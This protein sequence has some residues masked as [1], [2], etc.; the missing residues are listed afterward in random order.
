MSEQCCVCYENKLDV[1]TPLKELYGC[2]CKDSI[3]KSCYDAILNKSKCIVCNVESK[4]QP[5]LI[6]QVNKFIKLFNYMQ[7]ITIIYT[8]SVIIVLW[9]LFEGMT[10]RNISEEERK[11]RSKEFGYSLAIFA[12]GT[13][14][15]FILIAIFDTFVKHQ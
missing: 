2:G 15:L 13:V 6:E 11:K 9:Y 7:T 8:I 14:V 3:H 10:E 4:F 1:S 5:E 12:V